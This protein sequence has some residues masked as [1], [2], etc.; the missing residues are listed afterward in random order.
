[1]PSKPDRLGVLELVHVLVVDAVRDLDRVE[2]AAR[3]VDP[4]RAVLSRGSRPADRG[5]GMRLNQ[6]NFTVAPYNYP[7][8]GYGDRS[9]L[10]DRQ[11]R[12]R[13]RRE[14]RHRPR[15]RAPSRA[16][17]RGRR[18][19]RPLRRQG[20]GSGRRHPRD[21]TR[22]DRPRQ[23]ARPREP[24]LDRGVCR[25][26]AR[27]RP[28]GRPVDQ[29]RRRDGRAD[30]ATRLRMGSSCSWERTTSGTSRSPAG[31]CRSC[32]PRLRRGSRP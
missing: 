29:Q 32:V 31:S 11:A 1:M 7:R 27:R 22:L 24:R 18:A 30:S 28:A 20:K 19:R 5:H 2:Q 14:Q 23:R 9:P 25:V 10:P 8:R 26:D 6:V 15:D 21:G 12:R 17:R 4:D 13:H 3:D 16:R